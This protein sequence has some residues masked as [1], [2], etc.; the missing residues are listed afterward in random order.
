MSRPGWRAWNFAR[1]GKNDPKARGTVI[2]RCTPSSASL[3]R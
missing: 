3:E 1:D 2:L